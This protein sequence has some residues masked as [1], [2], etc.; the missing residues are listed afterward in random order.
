MKYKL[1]NNKLVSSFEE[2]ENDIQNPEIT[3]K[4]RLE[5]RSNLIPAQRNGIYY[6][7]KEESEF[8]QS[9]N[10]TYDF[11]YQT[12]DC[13]KDF[14]KTDYDTSNW[15][16]ITVPSMWQFSGYG[17]FRYTNTEYAFAL[18]PPYICCENPVG[19]Y[20]KKFMIT[21]K[22]DRTILH[23]GGVDNAFYVYINGHFAG[24][25]KGSRIPAEFD[26]SEFVV[27]G[28][29]VIAVKVFTFSDAS[30]LECQDMMLASGIFRDVYLIHTNKNS[31]WD[32]RVI[33]TDNSIKV[34]VELFDE[35]DD[36]YTVR[37]EL[38][39]E[40]AQLS[41]APFEKEFVLKNP[42][43]WNAE[44]P[45]LYNLTIAINDG[46][47]DIEIH[48]KK[49]GIMHTKIVDG[50]FLVNGEPIYIK[51][52]NRHE[53]NPKSGR[54]ITVEQI[55]NELRMIKENNLNAI[56]CAHYTNHPA[57]YELC[58]E[59]GLYVMDEADIETHGAYIQS[60]ALLSDN[61][62]WEKAYLDR[63]KRM[64]IQNKN[65]V[66]IFMRSM[67]NE[68]GWGINLLK[69][70]DFAIK[71]NPD[72]VTIHDMEGA[73]PI[74]DEYK[75]SDHNIPR[76]GYGGRAQIEKEARTID[77]YMW[78]EYGH[79][80]GNSPGYLEQYWDFVYTHENCI[81]GFVWEFKNHGVYREDENNNPYY[82]YGGD[83]G[84]EEEYHWN[85]F[86]LD[87]YLTADGTPKPSWHE[88]KEV[89]APVWVNFDEVITVM[90][91]NDFKNLDYLYLKYEL[92]EDGKIIFEDGFNMPSVEPHKKAV[93]DKD[94]IK[95]VPKE[96]KS[97]AKYYLNLK[98][99]DGTESVSEKQIKLPYYMEKEEYLPNNST[100]SLQAEDD[101][102]IVS[103]KDFSVSFK[104]G[105][106][107]RYERN[108][109]VIVDDAFELNFFRAPTDNDGIMQTN[110]K[111]FLQTQAFARKKGEWLA[112]YIH[113]YKYHG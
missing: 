11:S 4:L 47:K 93:F 72:I 64:V 5:P 10:G 61:P 66:C 98:F 59:I 100:L 86:C 70:Q 82:A 27:E 40:K 92:L 45:N 106:I 57:F 83:L 102:I 16:E 103:G 97:G 60:G 13:I 46:E 14:Y 43:L 112:H 68:A 99:Y 85:N 33:T 108:G 48:S 71:Y 96:I 23:F 91:T 37:I 32:Y 75:H 34:S 50:K 101:V 35:L 74:P 39:G 15:D 109:N 55:E 20:R 44:E 104:N 113:T 79:A 30:Y 94:T 12:T 69:C 3:N 2:Y 17:R 110:Y 63:V 41:K 81:G 107:C 29:N 105:M 1:E 84:D 62:Q 21:N 90:N 88:L 53:W 8:L 28:E 38:D 56:R 54:A 73:Y 49:V 6:K 9:L 58:S 36:N 51:G 7:N 42:K 67:C 78:I 80:M 22:T 65:E 31:V 87:G 18:N 95:F 24:F 76:M 26:V 77:T 89:S 19:Y 52:V 111:N 25:S